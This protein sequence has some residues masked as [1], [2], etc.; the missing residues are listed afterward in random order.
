MAQKN[1]CSLAGHSFLKEA[2]LTRK[3]GPMRWTKT[4]PIAMTILL[5]V[6]LIAALSKTH[7]RVTQ[8]PQTISRTPEQQL[9]LERAVTTQRKFNRYF[10]KD[11]ITPKLKDCWAR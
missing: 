7:S 4:I 3:A 2:G 6:G 5:G 8:I 11:V 9:T 10:Q 1:G